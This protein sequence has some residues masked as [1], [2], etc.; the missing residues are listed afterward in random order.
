MIKKIPGIY[1][2]Y[3]SNTELVYVGQSVDIEKRYREH[4]RLLNAGK[5]TKNC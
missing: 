3:F 4:I 2:L 1:L 5:H